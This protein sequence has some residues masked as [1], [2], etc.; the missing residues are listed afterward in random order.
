MALVSK[1]AGGVLGA[2]AAPARTGRAPPVEP[3]QHHDAPCEQTV[4][5]ASGAPAWWR[6]LTG[7]VHVPNDYG[8]ISF[9]VA[10]LQFSVYDR[11]DLFLEALEK[12]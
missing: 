3:R 2:A 10:E 1:P 12:F 4:Q 11:L 8:S 6:A 5:A 7:Q 9:E